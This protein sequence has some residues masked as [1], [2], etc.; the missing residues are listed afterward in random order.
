MD[1]VAKGISTVKVVPTSGVESKY[2]LPLAMVI[3]VL[4]MD[5]PMPVPEDLDVK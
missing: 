2:I 5:K 3:I 4:H 1:K